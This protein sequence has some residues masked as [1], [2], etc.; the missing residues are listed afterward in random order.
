MTST[1]Q[2]AEQTGSRGAVGAGDPIV[3]WG[4]R[5]RMMISS[6]IVVCICELIVRFLVDDSSTD[7]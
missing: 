6:L 7:V 5:G 2:E 4:M 1:G 3:S